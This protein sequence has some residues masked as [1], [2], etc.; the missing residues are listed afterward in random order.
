MT[1][2]EFQPMNQICLRIR[3]NFIGGVRLQWTDV[4]KKQCELAQISQRSQSSGSPS[5]QES[6]YH[7][8]LENPESLISRIEYCFIA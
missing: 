3:R 2:S 7:G 5:Y 6:L 4:A 8:F 1:N